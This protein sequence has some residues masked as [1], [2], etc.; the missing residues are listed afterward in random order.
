[1]NKGKRN[2]TPTRNTE[3]EVKRKGKRTSSERNNSREFS[4]S[5]ERDTV[6]IQEAKR[7][8]N[9]IDPNKSTPRHTL[10][11]MAK[12]KERDEF[13]KAIREKKF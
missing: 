8:P 12:N 6:Q 11:Q 1:M 2:N 5:L 3:K 4:H 7:V 10:T 9:K 13:F